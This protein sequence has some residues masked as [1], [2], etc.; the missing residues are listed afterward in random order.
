MTEANLKIVKHV[1]I[2]PLEKIFDERIKDWIED[3]LVLNHQRQKHREKYRKKICIKCT[4]E[5]KKHRNCIVI[6]YELDK[7]SCSHMERAVSK[8]FIKKA[9]IHTASHPYHLRINNIHASNNDRF[10]NT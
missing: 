8:K 3:G 1:P 5:Q 7:R 10:G 2:T 9:Q 4:H 6:D